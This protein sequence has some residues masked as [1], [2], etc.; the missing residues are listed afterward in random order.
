LHKTGIKAKAVRILQVTDAHLYNTPDQT[1]VGMNCDESL[2][3]VLELI[4]SGEPAAEFLLFTGDASQ[5]SSSA[6]YQRLELLLSSLGLPQAWI[7]GNHD[8][9]QQMQDAIGRD[10]PCFGNSLA[11][12]NWRII[13]L[14]S[15]VPG[16][17]HGRLAPTE[18]DF[19]RR[20]LQE[21]QE[22]HILV[23]L[24]H[25]PVPVAAQWLQQHALKNPEDLFVLL[26]TD[27]R[28]RA[29]VFG[30]IHH[31]LKQERNGV[32]YLGAPSTCVQFHPASKE[33]AL[34]TS[35]PGYRWLELSADGGLET[36]INRVV[37]KVYK[38]DYS[39]VG[40]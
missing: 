34:D 3:D 24:H 36:G 19:L 26:D 16:Q 11:L 6:S 40:Y 2:Q 37:G 13:L 4:R 18:L 9:L 21:C 10:N 29:V 17:V 33:F 32:L 38:V 23:C 15:S 30:H 20:Q 22:A 28:V 12:G 14:N 31:E 8:E 27:P 35:N 39:G 7:P 1:L 5:D 25:N